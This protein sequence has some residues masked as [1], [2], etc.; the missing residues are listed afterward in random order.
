MSPDHLSLYEAAFCLLGQIVILAKARMRAE[1]NRP[2]PNRA[3][4][5]EWDR[6]GYACHAMRCSLRPDDEPGQRAIVQKYTP[7]MRSFSIPL[8]CKKD[9]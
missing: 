4:I 9:L 3:R 7:V 2:A 6:L 5:E 8:I 1:C